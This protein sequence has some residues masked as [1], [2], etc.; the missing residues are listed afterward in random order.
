MEENAQCKN[1]GHPKEVLYQFPLCKECR[2]ILARRPLPLW[3]KLSFAMVILVLCFAFTRFPASL[4]AGI[5][6]ER[7]RRAEAVRNFSLAVD[8]YQKVLEQFSDSTLVLARF[9]ISQYKAD[10]LYEAASVFSKL[11][12]RKT[13]KDLVKEV[14]TAIEEMNTRSN[15]TE[16]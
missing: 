14:N 7:G 9:G 8:E 2:D 15:Q 4:R 13:S 12:G 10:H 1:C 6:F 16:R 3:T 11:A 5:A